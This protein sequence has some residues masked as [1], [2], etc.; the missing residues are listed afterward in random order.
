VKRALLTFGCSWTA[1]IGS[2]YT[3][4]MSEEEL[5]QSAWDNSI[6]D[7]LS[8]RGLLSQKYNLVNKNWSEGGSS[9]Q[10]Q[11]RLAKLFFSSDEFKLL[12]KEFDQILVLWGITSTARNEMFSIEDNGLTNFFYKDSMPLAK[13]LM[14]YSYNHQHEVD[15]LAIE[16]HHWDIFFKNLN[17]SNLWFDTFNHHDYALPCSQNLMFKDENP[18]DLMSKLAIGNGFTDVDNKYHR[19]VWKVDSNRVE[20]LIKCE[21]INP[22]SKHPTQK[23]HAQIADMLAKYIEAQL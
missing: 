19:A 5:R 17:I 3:E 6:N 21:I 10:R 15:Q 9:N 11:F 18:R 12:Q 20:N 4:G 22:L 8:F 2:C 13:M 14:M 23:G 7:R 16:M 1:G